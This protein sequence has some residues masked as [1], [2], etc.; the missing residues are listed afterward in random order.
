[1]KKNTNIARFSLFILL[2]FLCA[3]HIKA[4]SPIQKST[5]S[6][7]QV[8]SKTKDPIRKV[9]ILNR[10]SKLEIE[11]EDYDAAFNT[12][13]EL[14][15]ISDK[16]RN[17][18]A[19][20]DA[21]E[22]IG[23]IFSAKK[24]AEKAINNHMIALNLRKKAK[25]DYGIANSY[26]NIGKIYYSNLNNYIESIK[27]YKRAL[28]LYENLNDKPNIAQTLGNITMNYRFLDDFHNALKYSTDAL[29]ISKEIKDS[30]GISNAY[31]TMGQCMYEKDD[32][33]AMEYFQKALKISEAQN[34]YINM[35]QCYTW[36]ASIYSDRNNTSETMQIYNKLLALSKKTDNKLMATVSYY[37][38]ATYVKFP[39]NK[40]EEALHYLD[41]AESG[42]NKSYQISIWG[43]KAQIYNKKKEYAKAKEYIDKVIAYRKSTNEKGNL[44]K[45]YET[46]A[47]INENAGNYKEALENYKLYKIYSDSVTQNDASKNVMKYEFELKESEMRARQ[48]EE[49]SRKALVSN[50]TYGILGT[51]ILLAIS[52][53]YTFRLRNKKL[54]AEKQNLELKNREAELA[55]ETEE[56]KARFL[57]N[58][59]HEFRTP[60]TLINGHLEILKK[61]GN[62]KNQKRFDEMEYS[63]QRLLQLI[64]QLL[65]LTKL[66]KN[67]YHLYYKKGD[68]MTESQNY[69]QAFH[70]LAEQRNIN[71]TTEITESAKE[72][73][74]QKDFAYSS[75]TLASIFNNLVSNAIKFTPTGGNVHCEIDFKNDN[76]YISISDTGTGIPEKD[77]PHI[78]DRFYQVATEEKPIYEGSGIGLAI[79]KELALLHN[80]DIT[81]ENN[82]NGGSTFTVWLSEGQI[83]STAENPEI[84]IP[85]AIPNTNSS[86]TE[87]PEDKEKPLILVVEDQRELRKFIVENLG[88]QYRFLEA[89]NGKLG[90]ELALEHLPDI[91]ISDV[92][93][94]EMNGFQL[95]QTLKEND[96]TSHIPIILL[97]AKSD[98]TDKIEGLETGADDYLTKPFS[99]SELTL[100]IKNRI[101]QQENLRKKFVGNTIPVVEEAPELNE[102]DRNFLEK[103]DKIARQNI[104]K[105][106]GVIDLASEIGLSTSQLTRKLK[107]LT[108]Q[109]PANFI[110]NIQMDTALQM[111]KRGDSVSEAAWNV[112]F[113]E[114]AYFTK[115][116]KKHFGFLPSEKE[117]L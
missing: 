85:S 17:I 67:Q 102:R 47:S 20:A 84:V 71:L 79:V 59:S 56:F 62:S 2:M 97:T 80:G 24:E 74:S 89:E 82:E 92:M 111:L 45:A 51:L 58:I 10:L 18:Q 81:A 14:I 100:R 28:V 48:K 69:I 44:G 98:Q 35:M 103:L 7:K 70:S 3:T 12:L 75:E 4:N 49:L 115:V 34:D 86:V 77:L 29:K 93:M 21:Y 64:N 65:D 36:I 63:G 38:I 113:S 105:E 54:S 72:K 83:I 52:G 41:L 108:G 23:H 22:N 16:T 31:Q 37:G 11:R 110:R 95:C 50:T 30:T 8:L 27:F 66:E 33:K 78:F 116:F 114:P 42:V 6:L 61:E 13:N 101:H 26:R 88:N 39:E 32:K 55:K 25:D 104:S 87:N 107:T 109:T 68:I 57:S 40:L 43:T 91:V 99:I 94:P 73:F 5:D 112:G 9:D 106:S 53:L 90:T 19:K 60:L 76:L 117:K 1:M 46:S 15:K 96:I